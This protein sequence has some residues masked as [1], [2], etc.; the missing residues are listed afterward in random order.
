[1]AEHTENN[2][3]HILLADD[4]AIFLRTTAN[5]LCQK[6]TPAMV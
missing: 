4:D 3:A 2:I 6:D 1:M 5:L